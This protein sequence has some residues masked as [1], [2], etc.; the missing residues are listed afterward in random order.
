MGKNAAPSYTERFPA[1]AKPNTKDLDSDLNVGGAQG[2][3]TPT[4]SSTHFG[5]TCVSDDGGEGS[6]TKYT[7]TVLDR[8]LHSLTDITL[9][10][11]KQ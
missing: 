8:A 1:E 11:E 10:R 5:R 6:S 7:E 4:F 3:R 2:Q 9:L